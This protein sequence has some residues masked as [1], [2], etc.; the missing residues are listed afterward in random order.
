MKAFTL[1]CID[2]TLYLNAIAEANPRTITLVSMRP[3]ELRQAFRDLQNPV[4]DFFV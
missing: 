3:D 4:E 1:T 2:L